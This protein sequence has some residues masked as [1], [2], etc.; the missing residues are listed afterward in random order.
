VSGAALAL[1]LAGMLLGAGQGGNFGWSSPL[2]VGLLAGGGA[3]LVAFARRQRVPEHRVIDLA[4][5]REVPFTVA[6]LCHVLLNAA[7]FMILLF[8]PFYLARAHGEAGVLLLAL[9]PIGFAV[10]SPLAERALRRWSAHA[11]GTVALAVSTAFVAAIALWPERAPVAWIA[12]VLLGAGIGYG[13]FQVA[14]MD[15]VM[16]GLSRAHQ[17]VA[18]SLNMVTRTVGVVLG[19][20]AGAAAFDA[21]TP[22]AGFAGGFAAVFHGAWAVNAVA[23]VLM[24]WLGRRR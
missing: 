7:N 11:V 5:F 19:A 16:G 18:G 23:A 14:V 9:A 6:N 8:V 17:G 2:T 4:L 10:G 12:L 20:S 21:V 15:Q 1:G 22:H 24:L 13:L 3:L